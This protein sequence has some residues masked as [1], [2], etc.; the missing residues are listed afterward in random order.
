MKTSPGNADVQGSDEQFSDD[1]HS[2]FQSFI[3][4]LLSAGVWQGDE[5]A[6]QTGPLSS[7]SSGHVNT[8]QN[9]LT[10]AETGLCLALGAWGDRLRE[11]NASMDSCVQF[12]DLTVESMN[13]QF[14]DGGRGRNTPNRSSA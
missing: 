14:L 10:S 9:R 3:K 8:Q 2:F 4:H 1:E 6:N 13:R 11:Q 5:D 12:V 7:R